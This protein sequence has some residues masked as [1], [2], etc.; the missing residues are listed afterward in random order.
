[1]APSGFSATAEIDTTLAQDFSPD[2]LNSLT[3]VDS[4]KKFDLVTLDGTTDLIEVPVPGAGLVVP[5][6]FSLGL[7][8]S[9]EAGF[10]L[11]FKGKLGFTVG[12]TASLPDSALIKLN[13]ADL[14]SSS[15]TGFE[16]AK[17]EPVFK[18]DNASAAIDATLFFRPKFA[19]K[20]EVTSVG[21]VSADIKAGLPQIIAN[22]AAEFNENGVC[23]GT[24]EKTGLKFKVAGVLNLVVGV[25]GTVAGFGGRL[26]EKTLASLDLFKLEKC[27]PFVIPALGGNDAAVSASNAPFPTADASSTADAPAP[28]VKARTVQRREE[29]RV[30]RPVK[31]QW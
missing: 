29:S 4:A 9:V 3:K 14:E 27:V 25:T 26:A 10:T 23:E 22:A 5:K 12:V 6:I 19:I 28:T 13:L 21:E 18:L 16:G 24:T 30:Y 8:A 15:A 1:V 31:M 17:V 11:S 2:E 7:I 20:C